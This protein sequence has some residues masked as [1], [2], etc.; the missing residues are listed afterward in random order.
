[1]AKVQLLDAPKTRKNIFVSYVDQM[2]TYLK[3]THPLVPEREIIA[4]VRGLVEDKAAQLKN[5]LKMYIHNQGDLSKLDPAKDVLWP[6]VKIVESTDPNDLKHRHSDGN[7]TCYKQA[8]LFAVIEK[9]RNK[10]ISPSGTFYESTDK[11]RSFLGGMVNA[12][13]KDRKKEKKL[14]LAAKNRNDRVAEVFHN[15]KQSTIKIM[16]NSLPGAMGSGYNFLS[17][18][19]N[20]NSVTSI[21]RFCIQNAY[22]HAER[23]LES[24]FYFR[25]EEQVINFLVSC[26]NLGPLDTDTLALCQKHNIKVPTSKE[27]YD[28]LMANH[29]RYTFVHEHPRVVKYIKAMS[30]GDRAFAF[31]M[32]NMRNLVMFN[33]EVFRPWCD[34]LFIDETEVLQDGK[35]KEIDPQELFKLDSDLLIVLSTVYNHLMPT[36]PTSG[37][38]I[39]PYETLDPKYNA[40]DVARKL[41]VLGK[42][43][44]SRLDLIQDLFDHFMNH[45]VGIDNVAAHKQMFRDCTILSDTDSIIFTTKTWIQWYNGNLSMC[46]RAYNMNALAVYWLSKA[47]A[48]ILFHLSTILGACG[49]DM[50]ILNMKNEFMMPVM[51]QTSRK[52]HYASIMKIQEGVFYN[53]PKLDIKGV[54]LRGSNLCRATLDY[55][56][57]FIKSAI[58]DIDKHGCI[59]AKKYILR[60]LQFERKIYDDLQSGDTQFLTID[61]IKNRDEYKAVEQSIFFNYLFWE[62]V[63]G[64]KYGSIAIPTKCYIL[65]LTNV[66]SYSYISYLEQKFPDTAKRMHKFLN[67][68]KTKEITRIPINPLTNSIPEELKAIADYKSIIYANCSPLYLFLSSFAI[69]TGTSSKQKILFSDIY[70]MLT[71]E[72]SEKNFM[73]DTSD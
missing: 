3:A 44:Q 9:Y 72:A 56:E 40:P 52:K 58:N 41:V 46:Q 42:R 27:L 2:V 51:I 15:K 11:E 28:F 61:P 35:W 69:T 20:Y 65:P 25:T 67:K 66:K 49:E 47:N 30:D 43:M 71:K 1:M 68:Y 10:I 7:L 34:D 38:T 21:A 26:K 39:T 53:K 59:S 63:F 73:V 4:Y 6:T 48:N 50:L 29:H 62:E 12:K 8:D 23:F 64:E 14:M 16:M 33:D 32:S 70:G 18:K 36:N 55:A 19:A 37:N 5:N 22:A 24:N 31:Y 13:K 60:T 57:W 54:G 45:H 17:S